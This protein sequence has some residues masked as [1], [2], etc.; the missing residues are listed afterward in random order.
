MFVNVVLVN[1]N[2]RRSIRAML[3]TGAALSFVST[4]T[5]QKLGLSS[6]CQPS[7]WVYGVGGGVRTIA[8]PLHVSLPNGLECKIH[9][10]V[11]DIGFACVLGLDFMRQAGVTL[12]IADGR[13]T[14]QKDVKRKAA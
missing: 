9:A 13:V 6:E 7:G 12:R 11:L 2:T 3:D 14:Y 1:G 10:S 4:A 5:V 8:V